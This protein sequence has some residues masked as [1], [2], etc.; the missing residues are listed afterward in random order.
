VNPTSV[1]G[2]CKRIAELYIQSLAERS[3]CR[4][5]TVRFG[6]VLNSAG[7]VVP[8]FREQ[9][10]AGGPVTITDLRMERFFMT[11]PEA[12]QLVIQAGAMGQ[13][14]EIFV[15]DMGEPVRIVDLAHDMI[16]LS[17]LRVGHDIEVREVGLRP[18]EKL[19]EELNVEGEVH[20]PTRHPKIRVAFRASQLTADQI[21]KGVDELLSLADEPNE[22]IVAQLG[23]LVAE[24][25]PDLV[26]STGLQLFAPNAE[27][28][29]TPRTRAA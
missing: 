8:L 12:A 10:A 5:V 15:L 24:Y 19:F 28:S 3:E 27:Q 18:G 23:R 2:T 25:K 7:S 29:S 11:I 13:G 17:G 26:A 21:S 22:R 1:M 6:N 4:F 14:G 20:Q 9:I 16:R